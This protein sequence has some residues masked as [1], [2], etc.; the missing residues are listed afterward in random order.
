MTISAAPMASGAMTPAPAPIPVQPIVKTR[1]NVPMNS[2]IYLFISYFLG[3]SASKKQEHQQWDFGLIDKFVGAN[4]KH[5]VSETRQA[6]PA[7][8]DL[9]WHDH[10]RAP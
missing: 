10:W 6:I 4:S 9:L 7:G 3:Q 8:C 5:A 1:K 2:V